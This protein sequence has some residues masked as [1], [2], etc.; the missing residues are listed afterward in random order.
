MRLNEVGN[1]QRSLKELSKTSPVVEDGE[2]LLWLR[3]RHC[4]T[5]LKDIITEHFGTNIN[6]TQAEPGYSNAAI[7]A[8]LA[9]K[10][11]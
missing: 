6:I 8:E 11:P 7:K 3:S 2:V 9:C 10:G 4:R 1:R 5:P